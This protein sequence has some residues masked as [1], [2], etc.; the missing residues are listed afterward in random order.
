MKFSITGLSKRDLNKF[1][2]IANT[3]SPL[4]ILSN[5][6]LSVSDGQLSITASNLET[7]VTGV[8]RCDTVEQDGSTTVDAKRFTDIID[9]LDVYDLTIMENASRFTISQ[10]TAKFQLNTITADDYPIINYDSLKEVD[11][12]KQDFMDAIKKTV[13]AASDDSSRFNLNCV[14]LDNGKLVATDGHRLSTIDI[15]ID[16]DT[17]VLLPSQ[18]CYSIL[19]SFEGIGSLKFGVADKWAYVSDDTTRISTRLPD[20]DYPEYSRV[21]PNE[22]VNEAVVVRKD[23][24]Q[25]I[26]RIIP[27]ATQHNQGVEVSVKN[28]TL[29]IHKDSEI[30]SAVDSVDCE[31]DGEF[32]FICNIKYITDCINNIDTERVLIKFF[33]EG[34]PI[35]FL[36][37][38]TTHLSLVMPMRK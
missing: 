28:N 27:L 3:R 4:P 16:I 29:T 25:A 17:K 8:F 30:G 35:V 2:F 5:L 7:C 15:A 11:V 38:G 34:K 19:K 21:I 31:Y 36:P 32:E 9:R 14:L 33:D 1:L 23:L 24:L 10:N 22:T 37:D 6:L 18:F 12:V 26:K 20:G 13:Y